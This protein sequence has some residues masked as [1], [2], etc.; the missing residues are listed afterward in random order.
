MAIRLCPD[1][2]VDTT[3]CMSPIYNR[4][5]QVNNKLLLPQTKLRLREG[6][7]DELLM[8]AFEPLQ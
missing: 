3:I 6:P 4:T 8:P 7:I 5:L 2:L 1:G